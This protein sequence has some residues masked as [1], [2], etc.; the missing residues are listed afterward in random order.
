MP[1]LLTFN[2]FGPRA[3]SASIAGQRE[4]SCKNAKD[5]GSA[6]LRLA[7]KLVLTSS[8]ELLFAIATELASYSQ[9]LLISFR[10]S[11]WQTKEKR[12]WGIERNSTN[13]IRPGTN[14]RPQNELYVGQGKKN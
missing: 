1:I 13:T 2:R 12:R 9:G 3:Q 14:F 8:S 6:E 4:N 11:K 5:C 10:E 7:D